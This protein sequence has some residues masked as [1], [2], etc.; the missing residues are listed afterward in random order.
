MDGAVTSLRQE[1]AS[2]RT[3]RAS[4]SMLEPVVISAYGTDMPITQV[5]SVN[6][7]EPRMLSV[8]VWD[9]SNVG[10][11]D[12]AIRSAG[13]GLNPVVD[14]T[15]LRI[16]IPEL[17]EDRRKELVKVAHS[18]AETARVAV[19]YVRRHGMDD[20]KRM[21]KDHELSQDEH[22]LWSEEVQSLTDKH[23]E[24]IN[25]LLEAKEKD[26]LTV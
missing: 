13:L 1:L 4:A 26:I 8:Q 17:T 7:P 19:R 10:A 3:G 20:L 9:K 21:E 5:A 18:Y 11:V 12:K 2:I 22:K 25:E 24:I 6:V 23:I 16:P 14:G 15:L